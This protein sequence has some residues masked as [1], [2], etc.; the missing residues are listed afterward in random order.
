[1]LIEERHKKILETIQEEGRI[2]ARDI[3]ETF[4]VAFDTARRDLR[5]LEEKGLLR[6]THGGAISLSKVGAKLSRE[7]VL[8]HE[9]AIIREAVKCIQENDVIF[10]MDHPINKEIAKGLKMP[11][12]VVTNSL[13][14]AQLLKKKDKINL[15]LI[16]GFV[17]QGVTRQHFATEM[18]RQFYF[19]KVFLIT[20]GLDVNFGLSLEDSEDMAFLNQLIR[21]GREI[22]GLYS[23]ESINHVSFMRLFSV[24]EL[25]KVITDWDIREEDLEGLKAS[26][27]EVICADQNET[28][29]QRL[30]KEGQSGWGGQKFDALQ[31]GWQNKIDHL[32]MHLPIKTG[33]ALELGC[34]TG[35]T[36]QLLSQRGFDVTGIDISQTAIEWAKEKGHQGTFLCADACSNGLLEGQI[37]DLI[38]DGCCLHCLYKV[39]REAFYKNAYR[40]L[41]DEG[42]FFINSAVLKDEKA[43]IPKLS[44][45][46]RC[47]VTQEVLEDE[48]KRHGF[49]KVHVWINTHNT[50][51]HFTGLYKKERL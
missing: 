7:D 43:P 49:T 20:A 48:L 32:M 24:N 47:V 14:I 4:N 42:Y 18:I 12:T 3:E 6:R 23:H 22:I 28:I 11:L 10:L 40:L 26:G 13:D 2:K 8:E 27:I 17:R 33:S 35:E 45:M 37:Y 21:N 39:E 29:Y 50:H 41:K 36:V 38:V 15:C 46:E 44:T 9:H 1:M 31:L 34:G 5:I 30:K 16:G 25:T 19:D 51:N